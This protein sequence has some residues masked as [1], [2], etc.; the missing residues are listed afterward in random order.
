[1]TSLTTNAIGAAAVLFIAASASATDLTL[2]L[3]DPT[4]ISRNTV[5]FTCDAQAAP[6]GLPAGAFTVEYVNGA[7][8]SLAILPIEGR[9]LIFVSVLTG[10]GARYAS[11]RYIWIDAGS[12]G[13]SLQTSSMSNQQRTSCQRV[14]QPK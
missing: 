6:L 7:G 5:V 8:N 1:M 12:R 14:G 3:S 9:S 10:S 4:P 2:H 13:V 11:G